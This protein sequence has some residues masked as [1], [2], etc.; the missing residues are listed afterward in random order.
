VLCQSLNTLCI[1]CTLYNYPSKMLQKIF[2]AVS[3]KFAETNFI[4]SVEKPSENQAQCC[5]RW[6][7]QS[8]SH[9]AC[10]DLIFRDE[11]GRGRRGGRGAGTRELRWIEKRPGRT[12][13][14]LQINGKDVHKLLLIWIFLKIIELKNISFENHDQK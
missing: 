7:K 3:D 8:Q 4:D 14:C 2:V 1:D 10:S 12:G 11:K 5:A 13:A 6:N 9:F